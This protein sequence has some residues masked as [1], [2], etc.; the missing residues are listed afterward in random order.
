[1][2]RRPGAMSRWSQG[3]DLSWEPLRPELVVEVAYDHMQGDALPTHGAVSALADRQAPERL[4]V[5]AARGRPAA[6]A[7]RQIFDGGALARRGF[8]PFARGCRSARAR[9]ARRDRRPGRAFPAA[10]GSL[11]G[12][13]RR[14]TRMRV[15]VDERP[16]MESTSTSSTARCPAASGCLAFQRSSPASAASLSGEFAT[17]MSGIF[18]RGARRLRLAAPSRATARRASLRPPS[19]GSAAAT[20]RRRDPPPHREPRARAAPP[21]TRRASSIRRSDRRSSAKRAGTVSTVK[22]A[23]LAIGNLVPLERRR[24]ARV[25]ERPHRVGRAGRAVLGVL[26]VVEEDA[27]PLLLPPFRRRQRR[28]ASLDLARERQRGAAH[29]GER[30]ARLDAH[31]DVH[32]ARAARLGP[33]AKSQL[34]EQAFASIAT[35]R[36]SS[37]DTP[38]PGSRSMRSSSG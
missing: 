6:R 35:R 18:V 17:T 5:R 8:A 10:A 36:T 23:G 1:M 31:V 27:V 13:L 3:K 16:R 28:R 29:L 34:V 22:S 19:S 24:Y 11:S 14:F 38:G 30:P 33:A 25:G 32:A 9:L 37:H 21:A 12:T 26:V 4:H 15:H 7:E 20:A 2:H